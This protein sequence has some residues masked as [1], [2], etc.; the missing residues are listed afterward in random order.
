MR[1]PRKEA[2]RNRRPAAAQERPFNNQ[3]SSAL[4]LVTRLRWARWSPS[5][6]AALAWR[7][8]PSSG[9]RQRRAAIRTLE[10]AQQ[11]TSA[12]GNE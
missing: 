10:W 8:M 4:D 7:A 3:K 9:E 12:T 1:S 2:P 6:A 11:V 5:E